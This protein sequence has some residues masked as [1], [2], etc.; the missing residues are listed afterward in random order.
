[1]TIN[2]ILPMSLTKTQLIKAIATETGFSQKET[3]EIYSVIIS[4]LTAKLASGDIISISGFGKFY[5][6]NQTKRKIRHPQTGEVIKIGPKRTVK[7]KSFKFLREES[8]GFVFDFDEFKRQNRIILQ[9]LFHLIE[10][11]SDYDEDEEKDTV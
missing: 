9:Q 2:A 3:S 7:F 1:M 10:N 8:N 6:R 4:I 5:T 11:S